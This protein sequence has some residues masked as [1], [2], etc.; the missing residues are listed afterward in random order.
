MPGPQRVTLS[1]DASARNCG[2]G[3]AASP[4]VGGVV[5]EATVRIGAPGRAAGIGA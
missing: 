3:C 5:T 4:M 2:A 1:E